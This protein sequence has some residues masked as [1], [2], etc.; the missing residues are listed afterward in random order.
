MTLLTQL[1]GHDGYMAILSCHRLLRIFS[2]DANRI[3][4][5]QEL[6]FAADFFENATE[7]DIKALTLRNDFTWPMDEEDRHIPCPFPF[8]TTCLIVGASCNPKRGEW[9]SVSEEPFGIRYDRY[10]GGY[11]KNGIMVL[12]IT[13]LSEVRYCFLDVCGMESERKVPLHTPLSGW[14]YLRAYYDDS[15]DIVLR[16]KAVTGELEKY[17]LV[18]LAALADCW[19]DGHWQTTP[20]GGDSKAGPARTGSSK[21]SVPSLRTLSQNKLFQYLVSSEE[22]PDLTLLDQPMLFRDFPRDLQSYLTENADTLCKSPYAV[23]ILKKAFWG[24]KVFD[25]SPFQGKLPADDLIALASSEALENVK[26]ANLSGFDSPTDATTVAAVLEHF[27]LDSLYL[28]ARPDRSTENTSGMLKALAKCHNQPLVRQRLVLGSAFSESIRPDFWDPESQSPT[29]FDPS[30]WKTFPVIQLLYNGPDEFKS[31]RDG[32]ESWLTH[33]FLGDAFLTPVQFITGLLNVIKYNFQ[34]PAAAGLHVGHRD[35]PLNFARASSSFKTFRAA[36]EMGPIPA[37]AFSRAIVRAEEIPMRPIHHVGWTAVVVHTATRIPGTVEQVL[38]DARF[39][40]ALVRS[41][42]RP[43]PVKDLLKRP[44]AMEIVD[45]KGF[46]ELTAPEQTD[47][48]ATCL[49]DLTAWAK[50]DEELV[51]NMTVDEVVS[52]LRAFAE[53]EDDLEP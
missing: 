26:V 15:D 34:N 18:E 6:V 33:F 45:L 49:A 40:V 2:D 35:V 44:D 42:D 12:D 30:H 31:Y 37:Q 51:S 53:N 32:G 10:D 25:F 43:C 9:G 29:S 48:L 7:A 52:T 8:I 21:M 38:A 14:T 22:P 27:K 36:T 28:L 46:L 41:K 23:E 20:G 5:Q 1:K 3:P 4:L 19:P 39:R 47:D 17:A 50:T 16:A 13:E 11:S 24:E